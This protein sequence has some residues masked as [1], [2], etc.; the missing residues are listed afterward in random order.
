MRV[1]GWLYLIEQTCLNTCLLLAVGLA[2]GLKRRAPW[3]LLATAFV[4]AL[5]TLLTVTRPSWLR[6]TLLTASTCL[7]PFAAWP[8]V[9]RR[10]RLR[11][12]VLGAT[13]SLWLTGLMR[14]TSPLA[15]PGALLL[16]LAC[17]ALS[18]AP[19]VILRAA[20]VPPCAAVDIRFRGK[21]LSLTALID[22]GNLLRDPVTG[23][24]VIVISGCAARRLLPGT[25]DVSILPG[26]RLMSVRTISGTALMPLLRPDRVG[27]L[28]GGLWQETEA[29]IGLSPDGY[30]GF[31]ALVPG[32]LVRTAQPSAPSAITQ[33]G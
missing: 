19:R 4:L 32:C 11:L 6:L 14:L 31:Q 27:I 5:L 18:A 33:G 22:T 26:V 8:G 24:P 29:L 21:Q 20:D 16:A 23:L 13:L 28:L 12:I 9:P 17:A 7:T 30:E 25:K 15:L 3:R 10:L 2:A 1:S